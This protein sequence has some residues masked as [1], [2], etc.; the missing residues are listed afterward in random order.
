MRPER[1]SRLGFVPRLS[2]LYIGIFIFSGIQMPF[3]PVWLKAK[4]VDPAFIGVL[5][6]MPSLVRMIGIPFAAR[7]ADRRDA[8]RLGIVIG[9]TLSVAAFV[10]VGLSAG[11]AL[12]FATYTL[13]ALLYAPVLP[14]TETY[15]LK[16]LSARGRAYGPVR[17]WGSAAFVGGNLA[18]GFAADLMPAHY[19]IWLLVAASGLVALASFTLMPVSTARRS[20][21]AASAAGTMLRD[22]GFLAV[23]AGASLIQ[24]SHAVFYSFSSLQW[25]SDGLDGGTIA[26]LWAIGVVAEIVLF[27]FSSRLTLSSTALMTLGATGAALRWG[28]MALN[29]PLVV[30]PFVQMLHA[31]SFGATHLGA[32]TYVARHAPDGQ[33]AT[34]QGH[35]AMALS[36]AMALAT[37][38]S[39]LLYASFGAAAYTAMAL[40]AVAGG[41]GACVASRAR[42]TDV[43][44]R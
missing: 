6:A 33:A 15:A 27:A 38:L 20:G 13:A 29:P 16:G 5:V 21:A 18:A 26:A 10:L 23:L 30:L 22:P 42:I 39:G 3:F 37:A 43:P 8:V 34:A 2:A 9:A 7:E 41:I 4:D 25:R 1:A 31:L 36:G 35:L 11:T 14:L 17:L 12:I 28:A 32:L 19:L 44:Q 24:A 40:M